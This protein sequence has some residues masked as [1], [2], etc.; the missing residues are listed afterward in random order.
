MLLPRL[1]LVAHQG[2]WDEVLLV[3]GPIV[4]IITVLAV[5]KRRVDARFDAD[6]DGRAAPG[7]P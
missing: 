1:A 3:A 6:S 4:V 2:G 7:G 5:A